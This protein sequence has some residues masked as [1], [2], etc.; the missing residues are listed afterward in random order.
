M[1]SSSLANLSKVQFALGDPVEYHT[2]F[3]QKNPLFPLKKLSSNLIQNCTLQ[4][5]EKQ[6]RCGTA[7]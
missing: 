2:L 3:Q 4:F 5:D 6:E 7:P 1:Y